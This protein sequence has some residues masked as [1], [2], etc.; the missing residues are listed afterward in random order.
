VRDLS[1]K[2][3][4][5]FIVTNPP[6]GERLGDV[7]QAEAVYR[8]MGHLHVDFRGWTLGVITN[9][10]GFE[11]HYGHKADSVREITNGA[12]RSYLYAYDRMGGLVD[13]HH[14]RAR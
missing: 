12:L 7:E 9:H 1:S 6:Y 14:R 11:S 4:Y 5:G 10:A 8:A 3:R 2:Q 13:V